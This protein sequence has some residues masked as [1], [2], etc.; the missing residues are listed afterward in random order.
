LPHA[1]CRVRK[2]RIGVVASV[3]SFGTPRSRL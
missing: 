1:R 3:S 2:I